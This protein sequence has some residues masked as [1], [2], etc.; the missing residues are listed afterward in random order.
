[1]TIIS[2]CA[3]FN[4][5][6]LTQPTL[7]I[8]PHPIWCAIEIPSSLC[9]FSEVYTNVTSYLIRQIFERYG[10]WFAYKY[11]IYTKLGLLAPLSGSRYSL[12]RT[13][14]SNENGDGV[15]QTALVLS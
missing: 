3:I 13:L 10:L 12:Y 11:T 9:L 7:I 5:I 8:L 6:M 4:P 2:C 15:R 14:I 1:M